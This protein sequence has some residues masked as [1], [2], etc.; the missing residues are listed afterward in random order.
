MRAKD[1]KAS[2]PDEPWLWRE[3][4]AEGRIRCHSRTLVFHAV[5]PGGSGRDLFRWEVESGALVNLTAD[6]PA[7][8]ADPAWSPDGA[9]I[10]F[11]SDRR[12]GEGSG[13]GVDS[14]WRMAPGGTELQRL[15]K[16]DWE[17]IRPAWSPDST[18]LAFYRW[19]LRAGGEGGPPGLWVMAADGSGER[20][21][22][23]LEGLPLGFD[24]PAWSPDGKWIAYQAGPAE[25][26]E[27]YLVTARGGVPALLS[28][29]PGHDHGVSWSPD[30]K[31]LLFT[32]GT[33]KEARLYVVE[34][35]SGE[36]YPLLDSGGNGPGVWAPAAVGARP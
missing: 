27:V 36:P 10:A 8:D 20:L 31:A 24:A 17:E 21:A 19:D 9:W 1:R 13:K 15:T 3:D 16:G 29:L 5:A 26:A 35:E 14:L 34:L 6:W 4:W 18:E 12:V 11:V 28:N 22:V 30:S 23:P 2:H 7:E 25:E 32:N 33:G